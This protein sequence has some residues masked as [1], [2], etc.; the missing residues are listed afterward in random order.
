[1]GG[2]TLPGIDGCDFNS[3]RLGDQEFYGSAKTVDTTKPFTIVTQFVTEDGTDTGALKQIN[4]FYVQDGKAIPNS[5]GKLMM[6]AMK[7][8]EKSRAW[9][10]P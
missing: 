3:F 2:K 8:S 6:S 4:R 1:M 7:G 10:K 5:A 9:T